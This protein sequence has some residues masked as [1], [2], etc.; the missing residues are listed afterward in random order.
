MSPLPFPLES[1]LSLTSFPFPTLCSAD[2][3]ILRD[4]L[5]HKLAEVRTAS[6]ESQREVTHSDSSLTQAI[7]GFLA[8]GPPASLSAEEAY[9]TRMRANETMDFFTG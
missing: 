6:L 1:F 7:D 4:M 2:W 3:P 9:K 8:T 5:K